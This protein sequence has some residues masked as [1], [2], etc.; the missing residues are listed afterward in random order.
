MVSHEESSSSHLGSSRDHGFVIIN[1][2]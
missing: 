1:E 2:S